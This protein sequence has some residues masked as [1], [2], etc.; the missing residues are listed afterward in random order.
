[1]LSGW[2]KLSRQRG[3]L[4]GSPVRL[5]ANGS[6]SGWPAPSAPPYDKVILATAGLV[7]YWKLDD[8]SGVAVDS[9]G[10]GRHLTYTGTPTYGATGLVRGFKSTQFS[11]SQYATYAGVPTTATDNWTIECWCSMAVPGQYGMMYNG[12]DSN[13]GYGFS[14]GSTYGAGSGL[15]TLLGGVVWGDPAWSFPT[16]PYTGHIVITRRAGSIRAYSNGVNV[17]TP[18]GTAPNTPGS[19]MT[20]GRTGAANGM[21]FVGRLAHNAIYNVSLTDAQILAHYNAGR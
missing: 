19:T 21:N 17:G 5:N 1:M 16:N 2:P 3:N 6:L 13:N 9:S 10:G 4:D 20:V 12:L 11:G 7:G 15:V 18:F 8:A 14:I